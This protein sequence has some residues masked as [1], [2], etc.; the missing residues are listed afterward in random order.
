MDYDPFRNDDHYSI[1]LRLRHHT[2]NAYAQTN[3]SCFAH[4]AYSPSQ[5][6]VYVGFSLM[7]SAHPANL[8]ESYEK[9]N[10]SEFFFFCVAFLKLWY[11]SY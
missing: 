8:R 7:R 6:S 2:A 11:Q 9:V 5:F 10:R 4:S 1:L 3:Q